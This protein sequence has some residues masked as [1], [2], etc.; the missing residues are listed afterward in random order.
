MVS[1]C[2]SQELK[3]SEPISIPTDISNRKKD[4]RISILKRLDKYI[5]SEEL[6]KKPKN[7]MFL[8]SIGLFV[9]SLGHIDGIFFSDNISRNKSTVITVNEQ[10]IIDLKKMPIDDYAYRNKILILPILFKRPDDDKISNLTEF[11]KDF[12]SLWPLIDKNT[13]R[14]TILL[15]PFINVFF[16]PIN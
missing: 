3:I 11:L 14:Q 1:I 13:K 9:D 7:N 2:F 8:F 10:L 16:D 5:K 12:S 4:V 6:F 15:T